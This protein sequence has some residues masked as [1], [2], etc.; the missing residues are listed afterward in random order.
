M[1][2]KFIEFIATG[3]LTPVIYLAYSIVVILLTFLFGLPIAIGFYFIELA[4]KFLLN[5]G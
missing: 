3:I 1:A 4:I 2:N 5:G